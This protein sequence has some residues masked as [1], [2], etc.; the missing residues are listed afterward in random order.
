MPAKAWRSRKVS[1]RKPTRTRCRPSLSKEALI[2]FFFAVKNAEEIATLSEEEG[3][4]LYKLKAPIDGHNY[5]IA[6]PTSFVYVSDERATELA[7]D[8]SRYEAKPV[9]VSTTPYLD[10]MQE[11]LY[12]KNIAGKGLWLFK[13]RSING[14]IPLAEFPEQFTQNSQTNYKTWLAVVTRRPDGMPQREQFLKRV[15]SAQGG[16]AWSFQGLPEGTYIERGL[17]DGTKKYRDY[18]RVIQSQ[19]RSIVL[20]EVLSIPKGSYPIESHQRDIDSL[21][22]ENI[23]GKAKEK[24]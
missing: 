22:A 3:A 16:P 5:A 10:A 4:V 7:E 20:R 21:I 11:D 9:S 8:P 12:L 15:T 2:D 23:F 6:S 1:A 13:A 17:N 19:P 14:A 18:W 24:F